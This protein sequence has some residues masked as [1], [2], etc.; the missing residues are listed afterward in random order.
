MKKANNIDEYIA[1]YPAEI[2]QKLEEI[3]A[4]IR[5]AAPKTTETISYG[6]PAFWQNKVL[7]YFAA[8]KNHLGFYPTS[9]GIADFSAELKAYSTSK[10]AVQFPYDKPLPVKLITQIVKYRAAED[11][12]SAKK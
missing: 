6:M 11:T 7:V 5:K 3:R 8:C 9:S 12:V 2:Q 4:I 10:G 1:D